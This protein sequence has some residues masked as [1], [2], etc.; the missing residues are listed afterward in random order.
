[1]IFGLYSRLHAHAQA[2]SVAPYA[3]KA[4]SW[5]RLRGTHIGT[6][7]AGTLWALCL[8]IMRAHNCRHVQA[9]NT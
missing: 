9:S 4:A 6:W 5:Q 2:S 1:M 7:N 3:G 8:N